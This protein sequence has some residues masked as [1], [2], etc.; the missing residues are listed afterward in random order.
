MLINFGKLMI[1]LEKSPKKKLNQA[2]MDFMWDKITTKFEKVIPR[3]YY[4]I[5]KSEMMDEEQLNDSQ[6]RP[7]M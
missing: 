6:W 2:P 4:N 1:F 3:K 7:S 5:E